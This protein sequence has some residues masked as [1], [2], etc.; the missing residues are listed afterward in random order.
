[1]RKN[2]GIPTLRL[3]VPVENGGIWGEE[4]AWMLPRLQARLAGS[5]PKVV[6]VLGGTNDLG[7]VDAAQTVCRFLLAFFVV[8]QVE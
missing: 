1:M 4:T 3:G 6:L 8:E 7:T 2:T 5:A